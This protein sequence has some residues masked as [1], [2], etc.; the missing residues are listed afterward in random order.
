MMMMPPIASLATDPAV[1]W[2]SSPILPGDAALLGTT[3]R[4]SEAELRPGIKGAWQATEVLGATD[5]GLSVVLPAS[6]KA[7]A[8][9]VR[10][11][12][13]NTSDWS[14]PFALNAPAPW[15]MFGD[16]GSTATPGGSVRVVGVNMYNAMFGASPVLRLTPPGGDSVTLQAASDGST[17]RWHAAFE[18]PATLS[19]RWRI[20]TSPCYSAALAT[21]AVPC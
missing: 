16:H 6:F 8:A 20:S 12:A 2:S 19:V 3:Q 13:S 21:R 14:A 7:G 10:V 18:I 9:S 15:F 11:R 17:T 4:A 1:F 5:D